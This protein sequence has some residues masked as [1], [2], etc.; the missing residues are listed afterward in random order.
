MIVCWGPQNRAPGM[1]CDL[2]EGLG[3]TL[4]AMLL[5]ESIISSFQGG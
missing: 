1:V 3:M 4:S 2:A 5:T